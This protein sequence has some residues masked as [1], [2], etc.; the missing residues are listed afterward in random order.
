MAKRILRIIGYLILIAFDGYWLWYFHSFLNLSILVILVFLPIISIVATKLVAEHM[1][2]EWEGPY[3][4][5]NKGDEFQVRLKLHNPMYLGVMNCKLLLQVSNLF[6]GTSRE[7]ELAAPLR[8]KHG[9]TITYP[10]TVTQSGRIEFRVLRVTLEDFL[11]LTAYHKTFSEV[12][13][14][15]VL[16]NR[17]NGILA[18]L[19]AYTEGMAEVEESSKKGSDFSEVQDVR[20]YQPGDRLQNIH[21][22]L[23]VKKDI[24]MVKERVSMSSRQ[25]FIVLELHEDGDGLLEEIL[26]TVYGISLLMIQNQ[27][28][29]SLCWWSQN[30]QELMIYKVDYETMLEETFR[31]LFF[32]S[33]YEEQVL[34][35][36]MF[37]AVRGEEAQFLW[38]GNRN[39]GV[40]DALMECGKH[41]GVFYGVIS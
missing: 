1:T 15:Y 21:W 18:D 27:I 24:L 19:N 10:I 25:L 13:V 34:G 33:I 36:E 7:H 9:Q 29:L 31:L 32:E 38:I 23:S 20:E 41:A 35:R 11:G 8:A 5:M 22:K 4:N 16:P 37:A 30:T 2:L 26:D 39:F 17:S 6:Y 40:G 12:Y 28:P 3:E 14:A